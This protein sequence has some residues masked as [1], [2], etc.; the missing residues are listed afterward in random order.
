[1]PLRLRGKEEHFMRR[2]FASA[3][4]IG[5]LAFSIPAALAANPPAAAQSPIGGV[6]AHLHHVLTGNGGC[7]EINAVTFEPATN[8]LHQ[9]SNASGGA[10]LGP[11][12]GPCP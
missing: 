10:E 1:M 5:A 2:F 3:L 4:T 6:G 12:H 8:G 9:G 11:F 7:V